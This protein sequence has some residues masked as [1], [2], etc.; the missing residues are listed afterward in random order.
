MAGRE[1]WRQGSTAFRKKLPRNLKYFSALMDFEFAGPS[2]LGYFAPW[3][4]VKS[5]EHA[6]GHDGTCGANHING[7]SIHE[8]RG[9]H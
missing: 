7:E 3:E 8:Q 1:R 6:P 2:H 5:L 4:K 9:S